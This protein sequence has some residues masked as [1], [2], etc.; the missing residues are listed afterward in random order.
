MIGT[1]GAY[2]GDSGIGYLNSSPWS[3]RSEN[4]EPVKLDIEKVFRAWLLEARRMRIKCMII[5]YILLGNFFERMTLGILKTICNWACWY[6]PVV[7]ALGRQGQEDW[8][9]LVI[10]TFLSPR[11][12]CST[13]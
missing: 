8:H 9:I 2:K 11:S 4:N 3:C 12:A 5:K 1:F 10:L 6:V 13:Q 7:S